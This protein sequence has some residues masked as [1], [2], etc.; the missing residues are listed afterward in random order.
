VKKG[1]WIAYLSG[2][3][4]ELLFLLA[5]IVTVCGFVRVMRRKRD[6]KD[7]EEESDEKTGKN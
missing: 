3:L 4:Y 6:Y 7:E 1:S 5:A 2:S